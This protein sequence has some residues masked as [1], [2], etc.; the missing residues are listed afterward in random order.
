MGDSV[1]SQEIAIGYG[2][3]EKSG[4]YA[5][6]T[7]VNARHGRGGQKCRG[8]SA[9]RMPG[10]DREGTDLWDDETDPCLLSWRRDYSYRRRDPD[11]P[12]GVTRCDGG[13]C[14]GGEGERQG[15]ERAGAGTGYPAYQLGGPGWNGAGSV[16]A[17]GGVGETVSPGIP[18]TG[19]GDGSRPFCRERGGPL[20]GSG[21][22]VTYRQ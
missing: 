20:P 17:P 11:Q 4:L 13:R 9:H 12:G 6:V 14:G 7:A 21:A 15:S 18:K 10:R 16:G 5:V 2:T 19:R 22:Q 8:P 1:L 3:T